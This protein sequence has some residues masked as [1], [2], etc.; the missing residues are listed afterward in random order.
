MENAYINQIHAVFLVY[1]FN[2]NIYSTFLKD[3]SELN[4]TDTVLLLP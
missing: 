3:T 1:I 2:M 4:L